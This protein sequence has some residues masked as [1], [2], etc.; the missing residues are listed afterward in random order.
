MIHLIQGTFSTKSVPLRLLRRFRNFPENQKWTLLV[1]VSLIAFL[2]FVMRFQ[3]LY[4]K[5][6]KLTVAQ[7]FGILHLRPG[8][9]LH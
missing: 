7:S 4:R 8:H 1:F 6:L 2:R 3:H 5:E 9:L